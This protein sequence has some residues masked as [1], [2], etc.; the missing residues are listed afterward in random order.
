MSPMLRRG[1]HPSARLDGAS[2]ATAWQVVSLLLDV[3]A[4]GAPAPITLPTTLIV[5]ESA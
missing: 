1:R 5:R 3:I 4:G 2:L